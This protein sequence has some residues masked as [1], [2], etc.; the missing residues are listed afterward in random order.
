VNIAFSISKYMDEVDC[1]VVPT[2]ASHLLLGRSWHY[3]RNVT[4][5][6]LSNKYSFL[7]KG[8]K[9]TLTPF[10]NTPNWNAPESYKTYTFSR[11]RLLTNILELKFII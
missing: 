1:D 2:E 9:V 7:F 3:D 6:S 11:K 10:C 5:D 8:Q 4:H